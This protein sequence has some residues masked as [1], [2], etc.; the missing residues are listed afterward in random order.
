MSE[1]VS[2]IVSVIVGVS[3]SQKMYYIVH[4]YREM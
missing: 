2:V 1:N 4:D 3:V